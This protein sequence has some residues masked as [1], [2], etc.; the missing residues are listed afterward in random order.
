MG[1][2]TKVN[3]IQQ[4]LKRKGL[5][6]K[7]PII[8]EAITN[9]NW[10]LVPNKIIANNIICGGIHHKDISLE[11]TFII[12][13]H[14]VTVN[15]IRVRSDMKKCGFDNPTDADIDYWVNFKFKYPKAIMSRERIERI[16]KIPKRDEYSIAAIGKILMEQYPKITQNITYYIVRKYGRTYEGVVAAVLS[17]PLK[18]E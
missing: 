3:S 14:R 5:K 10:E 4:I 2:R 12:N 17:V 6:V 15:L 1:S 11:K 13:G 16:K 9:N 7:Y 8:L 18:Y